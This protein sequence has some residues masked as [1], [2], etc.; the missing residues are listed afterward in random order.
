VTDA[1]TADAVPAARPHGRGNLTEGSVKDHLVRLSVPMTWGILVMISFQLVDTFYISLLGTEPLAAISFTFPITMVIFS[2]TMGFSIA[3]SSVLSRLIGSGNSELIH[4]VTTHGLMLVLIVT[5]IV[6]MI[7]YHYQDQI[8]ILLGASEEMRPMIREY[9]T[10]WFVGVV[11]VSLPMIGNSAI[12]A[13][14]DA[15][16]PAM[17][18]TIAALLNVILAPLM[19]FGHAGFPPMGLEGAACAT[20]FAN[21]IAMLAGLYVIHFR[22]KLTDLSY[23]YRLKDFG[24]SAKRILSVALPVGLTQAIIPAVNAFMVSL[25]AT[26]GHAAVAAYG[27]VSRVEAFAFIILMGVA[28][29]MGPII[30]QNIGANKFARAREAIG[31]AI[32]FSVF[33]SIFV[34]VVLGVFGGMIANAFSA[35]PDVIHYVTLFFWIVPFSYICSNLLR[36]W[37]SAF[38]A[39][40]LPK[41]SFIMI[42]TGSALMIPAAYVG[43]TMAGVVGLYI[44]IAA[45]NI[46]TGIVFHIWA[47]KICKK[48]ELKAAA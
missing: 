42:V 23:L 7:G 5:G 17:I 41:Q 43:H 39:M 19:I 14:G 4:R 21:M 45:V 6:G 48:M 24:D 32:R 34:A 25:L 26:S 15:R 44:A 20:V 12:R 16:V 8:F 33:W 38:N 27:I 13:A 35:E 40:G 37:G 30:G 2:V 29:G 11:F 47:W 46:V 36:G 3:M 9:M 10:P 22:K 1:P 18:M 31:L 28:V